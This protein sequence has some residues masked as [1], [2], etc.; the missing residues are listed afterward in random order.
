M[1]APIAPIGGASKN[2][3]RSI[4]PAVVSGDLSDLGIYLVAPPRGAIGP[5]LID[6][7]LRSP[8]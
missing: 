4:G 2:Q 6:R 1:T 3:A 7:Y 8:T 5:L